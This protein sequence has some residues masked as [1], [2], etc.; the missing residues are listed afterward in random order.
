MDQGTGIPV[1]GRSAQRVGRK[2]RW[3]MP[4]AVS[5]LM[6]REMASTYGRTPGGYAWAILEPV[7]GIALLSL[8]FAAAFRAPPVGISFPMF[9]ASG[10]LPFMMFSDLH[11]KIA[12]SLLFSKQ[13]LAYPS[14]TF[15]DAIVARLLLNLMTALLVAYLI[16]GGCMMI[17]ETRVDPDLP[18]II[19]GF[20]LS[21]LLALGVGCLNCYLFTRFNLMQRAW[22]IL[23]RPM[24][25]LSG[26]VFLYEAIP[27]AFADYLWYN[28]LI[29]VVGIV[30]KGFYP[31]YN[32]S[33]VSPVYVMVV[34]LICMALGLV[35]LRRHHRDMLHR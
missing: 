2:R 13:L 17:F 8:V 29:H 11:G 30:R 32:A 18:V 9:Y 5:A 28:P 22:S 1:G 34:S 20:A 16:L 12:L 10:M 35:M 14:V 24:F 21:A 15:V 23:M 19:E 25:L 33:Y 27:P 6:L 31:G 26:V 4:R 3:A 7:A